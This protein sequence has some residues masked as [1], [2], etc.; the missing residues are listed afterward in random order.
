MVKEKQQQDDENENEN[1]SAN[2]SVNVLKERMWRYSHCKRIC[3][4]YLYM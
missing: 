4:I 2:T 3:Y 1:V